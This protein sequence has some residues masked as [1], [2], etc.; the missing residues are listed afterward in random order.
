MI[1][2]EIKEIKSD[3]KE[4]RKFG[5]TIGIALLVIGAAL[6]YFGKKSNTYFIGFGA[7]LCL[8]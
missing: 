3:K 4:L 2:E 7:L 5:Y 1:L 8:S 6:L